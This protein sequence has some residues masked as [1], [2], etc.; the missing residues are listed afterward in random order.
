MLGSR[1]GGIPELVEPGCGL[2]FQPRDP[3]DI[4][5]T[6]VHFLGLSPQERERMSTHAKERAKLH[7]KPRHLDRTEHLYRDAVSI[8]A[9]SDPLPGVLREFFPLLEELGTDLRRRATPRNPTA[10][11]LLRA[12]ARGLGLPKVIR[13]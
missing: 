7:D 4:A 12:I 8:P 11:S 10:L 3:A 5:R 2:T 13:D 1:I 6:V 9:A